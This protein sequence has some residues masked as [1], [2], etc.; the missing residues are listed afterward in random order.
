MK[1][2]VYLKLGGYVFRAK[3]TPDNVLILLSFGRELFLN[4]QFRPHLQLLAKIYE[5]RN[6]PYVAV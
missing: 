5:Y 4:V 6:E 2:L 1:Y 3:Y